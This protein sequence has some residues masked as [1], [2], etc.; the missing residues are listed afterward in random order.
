[1]SEPNRHYQHLPGF[2]A[3]IV[4]TAYAAGYLIVSQFYSHW[5][6][7]QITQEL[8]KAEYIHIGLLAI[9]PPLAV[10]MVFATMQH[11]KKLEKKDELYVSKGIK[12][13]VSPPTF[14][15]LI[16]IIIVFYGLIII[17]PQSVFLNGW[18]QI[19]LVCLPVVSVAALS[20]LA[21]YR[22][23][24]TREFESRIASAQA[25]EHDAI[26]RYV[27]G[28]LKSLYKKLEFS[29][30]CCV[31][32]AFVCDWIIIIPTILYF[33]ENEISRGR[34]YL[35]ALYFLLSITIGLYISTLVNIF[36]EVHESARTPMLM[37]AGAVCLPLAYLAILS[38]A[39]GLFPFIPVSRGGANYLDVRRIVLHFSEN[40]SKDSSAPA[41]LKDQ[42]VWLIS[43]TDT[44]LYV[45]TDTDSDAPKRWL[46]SDPKNMPKI[47]MVSRS[48]LTSW[49]YQNISSPTQ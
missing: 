49:A 12:P 39:F 14:I 29:K 18:V 40:A 30:W 41:A 45:A 21:Y 6:I 20:F 26:A 36:D 23:Y 15:L 13:T 31:G 16:N 3:L 2:I 1:M 46:D 4:G 22:S 10:G 8:F 35:I 25:D 33:H 32:V 11:F 42:N 19:A 43:E 27:I 5:G 17:A 37:L 47:Q 24:L 48:A 38:F 28:D 9:T 44:C 34:L 7:A